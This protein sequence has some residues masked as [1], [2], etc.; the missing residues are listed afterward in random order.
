MK[1]KRREQGQS[2]AEFALV[3]PIVLLI[4]AGVLDLGR[5]YFSY[6]AVT[7]AA[8]EGAAYASLH[9]EDFGGVVLRGRTRAVAWSGSIPTW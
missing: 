7:D 3:L 6:V 8:A 2:L 4:L 5:A 1:D 9:P